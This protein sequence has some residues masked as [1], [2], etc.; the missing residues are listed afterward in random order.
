MAG[1]QIL[2]HHLWHH[3]ADLSAWR[4]QARWI[5]RS[6][7]QIEL[8]T[9]IFPHVAAHGPG[10]FGN[11]LELMRSAMSQPVGE[12]VSTAM[13]HNLSGLV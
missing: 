13:W 4:T 12:P 9:P 2:P 11:S 10:Y 7:R 6:S 5:D 8:A 3:M 1:V